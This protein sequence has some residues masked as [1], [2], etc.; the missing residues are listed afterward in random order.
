MVTMI[1]SIR[2]EMMSMIVSLGDD[3]DEVA[4]DIVIHRCESSPTTSLES[5]ARLTL[6]PA[7][8]DG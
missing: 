5:G 2:G 8:L 1:D 7:L 4:A 3:N 6:A